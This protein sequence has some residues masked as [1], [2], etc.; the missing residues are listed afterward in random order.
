MFDVKIRSIIM[1]P[2]HPRDSGEKVRRECGDSGEILGREC[3]ES[4]KR[5]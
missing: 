2:P 3:G 5:V 4:K 1:H